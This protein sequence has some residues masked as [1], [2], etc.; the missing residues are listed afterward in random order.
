MSS[1]YNAPIENRSPLRTRVVSRVQLD[2]NGTP[3]KQMPIKMEPNIVVKE[4]SPELD[5]KEK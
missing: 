4:K 1:V 2:N 5:E 3:I